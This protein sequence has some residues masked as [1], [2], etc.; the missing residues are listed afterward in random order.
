VTAI[1]KT[2]INTVIFY[3]KKEIKE[4]KVTSRGRGGLISEIVFIGDPEMLVY[5]IYRDRVFV[6]FMTYSP[7]IR[8]IC[9]VQVW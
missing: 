3:V 6:K 1:T 7:D 8:R 4:Q 2:Q 5:A 9:S